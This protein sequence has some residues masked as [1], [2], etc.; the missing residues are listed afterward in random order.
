M[1][2]SAVLTFI[3]YRFRV[4]R[5]EALPYSGIIG[6]SITFSGIYTVIVFITFIATSVVVTRLGLEKKKILELSSDVAGRRL[7]QVLAVGAVPAIFSI[8]AQ[9]SYMTGN[10]KLSTTFLVMTLCSICISTADTWA[11]EIG[12]LSRSRPRLII[13]PRMKVEPGVSGG[14]TLLGELSSISAS[15]IITM[16]TYT[17]LKLVNT[18]F[19]SSY[20]GS[21]H[22]LSSINHEKLALLI[23]ISGIGGEVLDSILGSL[24]QPK[25]YCPKCRVICESRIHKCGQNAMKLSGYEKFSNELTNMLSVIMISLIIF[26]IM[27]MYL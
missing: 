10:Y 8:I 22:S 3:A 25:Y 15:I 6:F 14:I 9:I 17:L 16:T 24:L 12:C 13:K 11:S 2:L 19:L 1:V 18:A 20:L 21:W 4:F 7:R 23:F 26:A 27:Y 5:R